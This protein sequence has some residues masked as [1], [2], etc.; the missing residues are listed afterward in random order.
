MYSVVGLMQYF[1]GCMQLSC[2]HQL[3]MLRSEA[4]YLNS[5][6]R[7]HLEQVCIGDP[8]I[9]VCNAFQQVDSHWETCSGGT[10]VVR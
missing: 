4:P 3:Q 6:C 10:D 9:L 1:V 5:L 7:R 8:V 2:L